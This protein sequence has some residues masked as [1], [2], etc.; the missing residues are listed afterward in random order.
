M[1]YQDTETLSEEQT[2]EIVLE[3]VKNHPEFRKI[4]AQVLLE[5]LEEKKPVSPEEVSR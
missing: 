1:D 3:A 4:F 2:K 5:L